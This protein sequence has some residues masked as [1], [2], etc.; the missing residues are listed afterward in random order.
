M[1]EEQRRHRAEME[2]LQARLQQAQGQ[3]NRLLR[4]FEGLQGW[5]CFQR[6]HA[7]YGLA[8][9]K[10]GTAGAAIKRQRLMHARDRLQLELTFVLFCINI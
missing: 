7:G 5:S 9:G 4:A 10:S 1:E 2:A 3:R 6:A 8:T